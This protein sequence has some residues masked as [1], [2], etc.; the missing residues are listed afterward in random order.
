MLPDYCWVWCI[1]YIVL[2]VCRLAQTY[3]QVVEAHKVVCFALQTF[4]DG[5]VGA[6]GHAAAI[7]QAH[8]VRLQSFSPVS[9]NALLCCVLCSIGIAL[10]CI[11]VA[12][13]LHS[14][15]HEILVL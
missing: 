15:R 9:D 3:L 5:T 1:A 4:V 2:V 10:P 12:H 8:P 13:K 7:V 6:A 14:S 11:C